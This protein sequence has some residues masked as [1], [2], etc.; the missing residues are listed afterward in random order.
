MNN[1]VPFVDYDELEIILIDPNKFL[2]V[3]ETL[4][5]IGVASRNSKTLFQ[6]C[7]ILHKK[8]KFYIKSFKELFNMD[9]KKDT[10]ERE[11]IERRN[12]IAMLLDEWKLIEVIDKSIAKEM[13]PMS[14]IR[15]VP[16]KE[17]HEWEFCVKYTMMGV[18][19][20]R[21]LEH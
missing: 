5:R 9:G 10:I 7:H 13:C 20:K 19:K 21:D 1:V 11:D 15:I 6:S 8:G 12:R 3:V 14:Y 17:K 4:S 2:C 18:K 16:F